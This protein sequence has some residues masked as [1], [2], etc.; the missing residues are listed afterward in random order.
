MKR[1]K[2]S[3]LTRNQF[4]IARDIRI[5]LVLPV[6]I[7]L[8][9]LA[10]TRP[11]IAGQMYL[12]Y[13]G[14]LARG[15]SFFRGAFDLGDLNRD[16]RD[17]MVIADDEGG[18]H[19]YQY[20]RNGFVPVWINDPVIDTGYIVAVEIL[21]DGIPGIMPQIL[22]LDSLGTLHQVHYTGYLYEETATYENYR[23]PGQTGRVVL[24]GLGSDA[25][26]VYI[27]LPNA[28][29]EVPEVPE[30]SEASEE[31][32]TQPPADPSEAPDEWAGMTLYKFTSS[33]LTELSDTELAELEE[34]EVY[35]VSELTA[36]ELA[37][38]QTLGADA[39]GVYGGERDASNRVGFAD[40][41]SDALLDLMVSVSDPER[42]ID[43]LEI[44]KE[45]GDSF[46]VRITLELPLLNEMVLGDVDGDCFTEIVGL[47]FDGEVL[48]YQYDPL[49][50]TLADDSRINWTFPHQRISD[51]IWV[52]TSGFIELGCIVELL[53]NAVNIHYNGLTVTLD[54]TNRRVMCG[55]EILL[56]D[57][58][59]SAIENEPFVPLF[60]T[61]ECLGFHYT[62]DPVEITIKVEIDQ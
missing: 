54:K 28:D 41:D 52:D 45:E 7:I 18:F 55:D 17:E 61:L 21:H 14:E 56:P 36:G 60:M 5:C 8:L 51:M 37:E 10:L 34:G 35:F 48:V 20:T 2:L 22:L 46:T 24:T 4:L 59:I 12:E 26:S 38:I 11:A 19:V 44:Y 43:R 29:T 40:F 6:A 16:G 39:T 3:Y 33:G 47:T 53:E 1:R 15:Y 27:A 30:E 9:L 49:D 25:R 50:V 23:R 58:P 57:V 42:P 32:D 31:S 62:Y 13:Q